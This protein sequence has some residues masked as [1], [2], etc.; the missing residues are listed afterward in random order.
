MGELMVAD[1]RAQVLLSLFTDFEGFK[2]FNPVR[3]MRRGGDRAGPGDFL[4]RRA[5]TREVP[6]IRQTFAAKHVDR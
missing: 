3:A 2:T 4:E 1:V 5:E 6:F